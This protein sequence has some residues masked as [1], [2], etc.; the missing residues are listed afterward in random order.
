MRNLIE[1]PLGLGVT[2]QAE[3]ID[4]VWTSEDQSLA[5]FLNSVENPNP[6][7]S[8]ARDAEQV[9]YCASLVQGKVLDVDEWVEIVD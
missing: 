8:G 5:T 3:M 7:E 4:G 1:V 6:Q 9:E 2:V